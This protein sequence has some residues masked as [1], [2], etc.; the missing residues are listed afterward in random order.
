MGLQQTTDTIIRA[1]SICQ[2]II[3]VL[4]QEHGQSM[5]VYESSDGYIWTFADKYTVK[6]DKNGNLA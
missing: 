5:M 2:K 4:E 1:Y 6:L 3:T